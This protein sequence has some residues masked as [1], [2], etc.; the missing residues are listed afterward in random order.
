LYG[1]VPELKDGHLLSYKD[2]VNKHGFCCESLNPKCIK[3]P[4]D[5]SLE[6]VSKVF[7]PLIN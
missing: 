7:D 4:K 5:S 3:I 2:L 6:D 1:K